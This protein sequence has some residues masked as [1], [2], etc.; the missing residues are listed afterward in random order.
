MCGTLRKHGFTG[1]IRKT[2]RGKMVTTVKYDHEKRDK[3]PLRTPRGGGEVASRDGAYT[4][5][6]AYVIVK[7][8]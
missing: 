5:E 2:P 8:A 4:I 6:R 3:T 1:S 7:P